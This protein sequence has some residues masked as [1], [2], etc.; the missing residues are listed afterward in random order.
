MYDV[1]M[2]VAVMSEPWPCGS[3][4]SLGSH[5]F[6]T[7]PAHVIE[8]VDPSF[9]FGSAMRDGLRIYPDETMDVNFQ[10]RVGNCEQI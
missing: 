8:H 6:G 4:P 3:R 5:I 1:D 10:N 9:R 2:R 7:V